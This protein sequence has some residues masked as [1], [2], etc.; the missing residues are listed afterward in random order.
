[1]PEGIKTQMTVTKVIKNATGKT[2]QKLYSKLEATDPVK[3]DHFDAIF[4]KTPGQFDAVYKGD[5]IEVVVDTSDIQDVRVYFQ[6][7]V[8]GKFRYAEK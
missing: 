6:S 5:V 7:K 4:A 1:M 2:S 8:S 3:G